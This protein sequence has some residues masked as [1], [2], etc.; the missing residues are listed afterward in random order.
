MGSQ[1]FNFNRILLL[2][3][4]ELLQDKRILLIIG[5]AIFGFLTIFALMNAADEPS[6]DPEFVDFHFL[7]YP[8]L[9]LFG[10]IIYTSRSFSELDE[11]TGA[12][13]YLTLPASTLEKFT[14][15]WLITSIGYALVFTVTYWMYAMIANGL[16]S[17]IFGNAPRAFGLFEI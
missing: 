4:A 9:L 16:C 13:H 17:S 12:H 10:G 3:K 14:S 6:G 1:T 7:W 5:G 2:L 11:K 8:L 15:K